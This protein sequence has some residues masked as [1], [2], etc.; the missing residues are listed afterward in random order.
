M[1][2]KYSKCNTDK[3]VKIHENKRDTRYKM[4]NPK[5]R[6]GDNAWSRSNIWS[7]IKTNFLKL[8]KGFMP[9]IQETL[10]NFYLEK[11]NMKKWQSLYNK[12]FKKYIRNNLIAARG[13]RMGRWETQHINLKEG[14]VKLTYQH[15]E[16]YK[17]YSNDISKMLN[18]SDLLN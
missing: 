6:K 14:A 9:Q 11:K 2:R 10:E 4:Y 16:R 1:A 3:R 18:E 17:I 5:H 8:M 15:K 7:N 12:I 13:G